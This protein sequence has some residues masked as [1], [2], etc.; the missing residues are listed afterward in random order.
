VVLITGMGPRTLPG[1]ITQKEQQ[2]YRA[3]HQMWLKFHQEWLDNIPGA[4]HT[5][6]EK[7]GHGIPFLEPELVVNAIS[8]VIVKA[9]KS[10]VAPPK[11]A[12]DIPLSQSHHAGHAEGFGQRL[13]LCGTASDNTAASR[14]ALEDV[15]NP[16]PSSSSGR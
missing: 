1:F 7:T 4:Q 6:T 13:I 5:I 16:P 10:P 2:E 3:N 9:K 15:S 12:R 8:N 11:S 14:S